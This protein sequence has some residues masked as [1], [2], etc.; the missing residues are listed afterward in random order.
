MSADFSRRTSGEYAG[1]ADGAGSSSAGERHAAAAFPGAH[2]D[3]GRRIYLNPV[4]IHS[5]REGGVMLDNRPDA[6][7]VDGLD[8]IDEHHA[9]RIA[10]RHECR[11]EY[12]IGS[13]DG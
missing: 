5:P 12:L 6:R 9:M 8:I 10:H 7:N 2:G 3:V 1:D 13:L 11:V 4:H